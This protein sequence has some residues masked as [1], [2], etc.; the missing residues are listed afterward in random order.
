VSDTVL[1]LLGCAGLS[2]VAFAVRLMAANDLITHLLAVHAA[3]CSDAEPIA[4]GES[5]QPHSRRTPLEGLHV[6]HP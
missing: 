3:E 5:N 1:A 2:V 4:P 6:H